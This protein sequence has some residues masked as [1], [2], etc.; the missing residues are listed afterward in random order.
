MSESST[1]P[2]TNHQTQCHAD[3]P[4]PPMRW[5]RWEAVYYSLISCSTILFQIYIQLHFNHFHVQMEGTL[6][7]S[8]SLSVHIWLSFQG[9]IPSTPRWAKVCRMSHRI[10]QMASFLGC[11]KPKP[12]TKRWELLLEEILNNHLG[13]GKLVWSIGQFWNSTI[14]WESYCWW[15][16]V[17]RQLVTLFADIFTSVSRISAIN[18]RNSQLQYIPITK[19]T[20]KKGGDIETPIW[21]CGTLQPLTSSYMPEGC[22]ACSTVENLFFLMVLFASRSNEIHRKLLQQKWSHSSNS[23]TTNHERQCGTS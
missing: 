23:H 13:L 17:D 3:P 15:L 7:L 5:A 12:G 14:F 9:K 21:R 19:S 8:L 16:K 2:V 6:S 22:T 20:R 11:T 1:R 18:S 4:S 10:F